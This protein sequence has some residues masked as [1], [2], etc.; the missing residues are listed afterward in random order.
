MLEPENKEFSKRIWWSIERH[1]R[2]QIAEGIID[3]LQDLET[4]GLID[5]ATHETVSPPYYPLPLTHP[6]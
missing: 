2:E 4:K 3:M 6:L 1:T 5:P